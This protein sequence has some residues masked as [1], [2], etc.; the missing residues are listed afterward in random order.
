[1]GG[2]P[3]FAIDKH[4]YRSS[5]ARA[6]IV[7]INLKKSNIVFIFI[8]TFQI[9]FILLSLLLIYF[10]CI[11]SLIMLPALLT[12]YQS[13]RLYSTVPYRKSHLNIYFF[14]TY[15]FLIF[16]KFKQSYINL[17]TVSSSVKW[18]LTLAILT[19]I[20]TSLSPNHLLAPRHT[21]L[22]FAACS[23]SIEPVISSL[24]P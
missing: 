6:V 9:E 20:I 12:F 18:T 10:M 14:P 7:K 5:V 21:F 19:P 4:C 24:V 3:L 1:M 22:S 2:N 15:L 8:P 11:S 16:S 13:R 23:L 17:N